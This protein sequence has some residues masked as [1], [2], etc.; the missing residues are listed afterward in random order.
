MT[1]KMKK[2]KLKLRINKNKCL[3]QK[4]TTL[5]G[6][7]FNSIINGTKYNNHRSKNTIKL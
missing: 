2:L 5:S 6:G 7:F 4:T 3:N 1:K